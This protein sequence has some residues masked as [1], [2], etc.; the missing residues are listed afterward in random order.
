MCDVEKVSSAMTNRKKK[1]RPDQRDETNIKYRSLAEVANVYTP[2]K[3]FI[4]MAAY[5]CTVYAWEIRLKP[6]VASV[7][8]MFFFIYKC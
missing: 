3:R 7:C 2:Y 4:V 6:N 8:D 5:A 1:M